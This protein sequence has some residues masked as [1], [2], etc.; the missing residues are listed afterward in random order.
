MKVWVKLKLKHR[1][2]SNQTGSTGQYWEACMSY[3]SKGEND[4]IA[5]RESLETGGYSPG[6]LSEPRG[7]WL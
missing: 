2:E 6:K 4:D 5:I 3:R 1:M 7:V